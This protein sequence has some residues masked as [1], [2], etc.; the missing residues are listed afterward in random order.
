M[1]DIYDR[2]ASYGVRFEGEQGAYVP[3]DGERT[4]SEL[5]AEGGKIVR[6]RWIGGEY[7]PGR[8]RCYDL[9]YVQGELKDGTRVR[10][11]QLPAAFLVPRNQLKGAMISWAKEQGVYAKAL[12][13]LED[14]VWSILG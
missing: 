12:G 10:I 14:G 6:V 7:I 1:Q 5:A 13:L 9:S 8:G 11:I 3:T 2:L 4:L